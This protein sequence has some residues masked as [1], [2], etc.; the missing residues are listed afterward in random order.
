MNTDILYKQTKFKNWYIEKFDNDFYTESLEL[1]LEHMLNK[2]ISI[3][4]ENLMLSEKCYIYTDKYA[5]FPMLVT[6]HDVL[7]IRLSLDSTSRW[8]QVIFQLSHELCHYALRQSNVHIECL[9]W[10]EETMCESMSLYILD[11]FHTTWKECKLSKNDMDYSHSIKEYLLCIVNAAKGPSI[12]KQCTNLL[13]LANIEKTCTL[14]RE[15]RSIDV[16]RIYY[17]FKKNPK[18]I[19]MIADYKKYLGEGFKIDFD[20]WAKYEHNDIFIKE[21]HNLVP[22][23][24]S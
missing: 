7:K 3:F 18:K 2:Y 15:E 6:N 21:L 10:F 8:A 16:N 5:N 17:L 12:L 19:Y 4:G 1:I 22:N 9:S 24:K 14:K 11:Y 23:L 20:L 13:S